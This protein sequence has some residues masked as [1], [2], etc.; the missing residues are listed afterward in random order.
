MGINTDPVQIERSATTTQLRLEAALGITDAHRLH[1][2]LSPALLAGQSIA[3]H[4]ERVERID[5]AA[6]QVLA[7]FCRT[8]H[9]QGL[10]LTWHEPSPNMR[11]TAQLL[12]L[13]SIFEITP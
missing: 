10:T 9:E 13:E 5:T 12:G 2:L 3:I 8:A 4:A 6:L 1:E 7:C 11:Q